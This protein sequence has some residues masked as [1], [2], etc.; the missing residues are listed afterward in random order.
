MAKKKRPKP[1]LFGL[2]CTNPNCHVFVLLG[3]VEDKRD[4][5]V[6]NKITKPC[7]ECNTQ[8]H[9]TMDDLIYIPIAQ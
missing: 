2:R 1:Y 7:M 3:T 9:G 6:G 8:V 5:K 4:F